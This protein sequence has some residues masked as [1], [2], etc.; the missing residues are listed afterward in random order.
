MPTIQYIGKTSKLCG[1]RVFEILANLNNFGIGRM[2]ARNSFDCFPEPS[3]YI[4][5]HA[6]PRMDD[7]LTFGNL[8]VEEVYRGVRK[9]DLQLIKGVYHPDYRLIPKEEEENHKKG[10]KIVDL[11]DVKP[12]ILPRYYTVPPLMKLFLTRNKMEKGEAV[13][14]NR[15]FKIPFVYKEEDQKRYLKCRVA[16]ENEQSDEKFYEKIQLKPTFLQGTKQI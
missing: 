5:K 7:E 6:E 15:D 2:L 1:K 8:W 9:P 13:D 12:H 10:Y 11:K 4:V 14:E 16:E 3:Y